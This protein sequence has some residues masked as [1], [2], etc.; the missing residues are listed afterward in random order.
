MVFAFSS[1]KCSNKF[2][3]RLTMQNDECR[4]TQVHLWKEKRRHYLIISLNE[5]LCACLL[6]WGEGKLHVIRFPW[7]NR[8]IG[9]ND[10][11]KPQLLKAAFRLQQLPPVLLT[12]PVKGGGQLLYKMLK[13]K[14]I[15]AKRIKKV[16]FNRAPAIS[17]GPVCSTQKAQIM[18]PS[19]IFSFFATKQHKL[20]QVWTL[21][22][23]PPKKRNV[24]KLYMHVINVPWQHS[25]SPYSTKVTW[26]AQAAWTVGAHRPDEASQLIALAQAKSEKSSCT[27]CHREKVCGKPGSFGKMLVFFFATHA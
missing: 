19:T 25:L 21:Q 3:S 24:P 7:S 6:N 15:G 18:S 10:V 4:T 17:V 23:Q 1:P 9:E 13:L 16:Q 27:W 5:Y 26:Q 11:D 20:Q 22:C 2:Y 14:L 8:S 12:C